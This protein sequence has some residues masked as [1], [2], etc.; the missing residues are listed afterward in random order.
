MN[1][2]FALQGKILT[3]VC[4]SL[5][6]EFSAAFEKQSRAEYNMWELGN[7]ACT[8]DIASFKELAR[9]LDKRLAAIILQV[10]PACSSAL[11]CK[12]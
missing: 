4:R 8:A 9:Q 2:V 12:L 1:F 6:A 7:K 5:Y 11:S 3:A 10:R